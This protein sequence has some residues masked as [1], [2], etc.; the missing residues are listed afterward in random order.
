MAR[1]Y[2]NIDSR[3]R[4]HDAAAILRWG[5]W[6]RITGRRRVRPPGPPAP[7]VE[8]DGPRIREPGDRVQLTWGGHA[9]EPIQRHGQ[10][11]RPSILAAMGRRSGCHRNVLLA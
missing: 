5:V 1:R 4:F 9:A 2:A 3:H 8:P 7:W 10:L 11:D 6:D